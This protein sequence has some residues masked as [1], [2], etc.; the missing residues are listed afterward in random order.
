MTALSSMR[1]LVVLASPPDPRI[2]GSPVSDT[3]HHEGPAARAGIARAAA[4]RVD[5][6]VRPW[7]R[8]MPDYLKMV[9]RPGT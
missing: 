5:D 6:H 4:V 9:E 2:L 7:S 1:L 3:A 8:S